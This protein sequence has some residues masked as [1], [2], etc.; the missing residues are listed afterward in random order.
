[1]RAL[2]R[3]TLGAWCL[4]MAAGV[5][6]GQAPVTLPDASPRASISQTIG[7]TDITVSYPRPAVNKRKIWGG[8]VPYNEVWRAGAN[9]NTTISLSTPATIGGKQLPAGTYGLH[10]LPG[11][12]DW[13]VML[14]SDRKS[15]RLN[16]SHL[17][18][19]YAVFCLKKKKYV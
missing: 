19:S 1:M 8:L 4:A 13:S 11:E 14:S 16:S 7:L 6:V 5:A 15:T 3:F 10:M 17:G 12:K 9:E 18:I 2:S